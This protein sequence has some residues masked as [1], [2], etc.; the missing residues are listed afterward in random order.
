MSLEFYAKRCL[1]TRGLV[2]QANLYAL[3]DYIKRTPKDRLISEIKRIKNVE[4]LRIL[5]EAGLDADLQ[6]AVLEVAK[7][8]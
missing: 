1:E 8:L 4:I 2:H 5:W 3:R 7:K 6:K